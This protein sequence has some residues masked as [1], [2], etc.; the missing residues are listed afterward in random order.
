MRQFE[1]FESAHELGDFTTFPG[2]PSRLYG[3][4]LAQRVDRLRALR[5][6]PPF[7]IHAAQQHEAND[8]PMPTSLQIRG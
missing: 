8:P 1:K 4:R 3:A 2:Q 5:P 6:P 7:P